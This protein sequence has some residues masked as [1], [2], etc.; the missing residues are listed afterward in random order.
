MLYA[1]YGSNLDHARMLAR[2]PG[3]RPEGTAVL[4][5]WRLS[6]GRYATIA[7]DPA[8]S[9]KLGLWRITRSHLAA[10]DRAEG[11]ALGVYERLRLSLPGEVTAWTYVERLYRPG[12]PEAWYVAHLRHGYRDFGL[13]PAPL[14]A[15][16]AAS[17]RGA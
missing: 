11:V 10:L 13:D 16:L 12:P 6:L 14:E 3:A 15:A 1:A 4:A 2:C 5:G 9:A 17:S 8:S 7:R